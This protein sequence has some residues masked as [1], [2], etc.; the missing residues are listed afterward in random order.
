MPSKKIENSYI[1]LSE[2]FDQN[3][4]NY[5]V[6][7]KERYKL[8]KDI[9]ASLIRYNEY[10]KTLFGKEYNP[11]MMA[12]KYLK[13][14]QDGVIKTKYKQNNSIGRFHAIGG[15][16]QQGMSV[17]IRHSIAK[18]Y[19]VDVD[20]K[21]CHPVVLAHLCKLRDIDCNYLNKYINNRDE[22]LK[23]IS[24][25]RDLSKEVMLS[26]L[27][28]G[29]KL[30]NSLDN[31]PSWLK[32]F[33]SEMLNIHT[34]FAYDKEFKAFKKNREKSKKKTFNHEASY[35]NLQLCD[36]ENQ[37]LMCIYNKIG[38][39]NCCVLCFDGLQILKET[40]FSLD[41]LQNDVKDK[42]NINIEL[43]IKKMD[44]G[45]DIPDNIPVYTP[46]VNNTFDFDLE[47]DWMIFSNEYNGMQ[48]NSYEEL[49]D[50]INEK[51][52]LVIARISQ[53]QGL[54]I[55][56]VK[57]GT[58]DVI[59]KLGTAD[60]KMKYTNDD[61]KIVSI[62]FSDY[63]A[64]KNAFRKLDLKLSNDDKDIFNI[65]SGYQAKITEEK[66]EGL[67]I[68]KKFIYET[69]ASS[70]DEYY[71]YIISWLANIVQKNDINIVALAM[72]SKPGCGK[73]TVLQFL[74]YI[75]RSS[76]IV[77]VNGIDDITQK[78]NT[79]IQGKRLVVINEMCS[80]SDTFKSNFDKLKVFIS[81]P[82]LKIE[83]KGLPAY[84]IDNIGNYLLFTNHKDSIIVEQTDRRYAL[85]EVSDKYKGNDEY[86]SMLR[87]KC[88]NQDVANAFYTYLMRYKCV[89]IRKI[90]ETEI[91][92]ELLQ[93]SKPNTIKFIEY[94][95]ENHADNEDIG[96][97]LT[98]LELYAY[99]RQYC[100]DNGERNVVSNTKFGLLIK[101]IVPKKK[102]NGRMV[103]LIKEI[104]L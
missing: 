70:N 45:L 96:D 85:F 97:S 42:L 9:P 35:T 63:I 82:K 34:E 15:M 94:F 33:K 61:G 84:E 67:E 30:F 93:I 23:E 13:N 16:S 83:P 8:G 14:S 77:E 40:I 79:I 58:F 91:R 20:I 56:K 49:D 1:N 2:K 28:G 52:K 62:K 55:K 66:P 103:Y 68:M 36:F 64:T 76:N 92:K 99:Y 46:E 81:D 47:Y 50:L 25:D 10:L 39:P 69:W 37:I 74:R 71:E 3:V 100:Q 4:L 26:L 54:Y 101:G 102:S 41:E 21:N 32:K 11:Y 24:D 80:T 87:E 38:K 12:E 95:K 43:A 17:E 51:Y 86:F 22:C 57:G 48:F 104:D 98:G 59:P 89:N 27:N 75:L 73:G 90:I 18:N 88:Y 31:P 72:I 53:G 78:H 6:Q 29:S 44:K 5:I 19:Y 65:W 7:N 60:F